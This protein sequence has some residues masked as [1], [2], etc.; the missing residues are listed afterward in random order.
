MVG[1]GNLVGGSP[2][3][4][5]CIRVPVVSGTIVL[6]KVIISIFIVGGIIDR[7]LF[8]VVVSLIVAV[9]IIVICIVVDSMSIHVF[10]VSGI[11]PTSISMN[12]LAWN[13]RILTRQRVFRPRCLVSG[14]E[15]PLPRHHC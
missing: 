10:V 7:T 14:S 11:I 12:H 1:G 3:G 4:D 13:W 9:G 5:S 15:R 8:S 6:S 2:L